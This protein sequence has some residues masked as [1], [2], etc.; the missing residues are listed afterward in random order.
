MGSMEGRPHSSKETFT[1]GTKFRVFIPNMLLLS[2][3]LMTALRYYVSPR[4]RLPFSTGCDRVGTPCVSASISMS[5]HQHN[6]MG[7]KSG[8]QG[9]F[10]FQNEIGTQAGSIFPL[11]YPPPVQLVIPFPLLTLSL[12]LTSPCRLCVAPVSLTESAFH[13]PRELRN[14]PTE[15]GTC[16]HDSGKLHQVC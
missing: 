7:K 12:V 8:I 3:S 13:N 9:K 1:N 16:T 4:S 14:F 10:C 6:C 2:S 5:I 15:S 11:K